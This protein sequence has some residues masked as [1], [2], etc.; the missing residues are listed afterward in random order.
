M[1]KSIFLSVSLVS[2]LSANPLDNIANN[3]SSNF[4]N[5][6]MSLLGGENISTL[7]NIIKN[8]D[9]SVIGQC[10]SLPKLN[11]ENDIC[12]YMPSIQQSFDVCSLA[13]EIPG[14]TKKSHNQT[15]G[16]DLKQY[17]RNKVK[18]SSVGGIVTTYSS[19]GDMDISGGANDEAEKSMLYNETKGSLAKVF[20]KGKETSL[21]RIATNDLNQEKMRLISN[22]GLN[23]DKDITSVT[24]DDVVDSSIPKND[25]EYIDFVKLRFT[26]NASSSIEYSPYNFQKIL[27]QKLNNQPPENFQKITQDFLSQIYR[28]LEIEADEKLNFELSKN[29]KKDYLA[30]PNKTYFKALRDDLKVGKVLE[31]NKQLNEE[32]EVYIKNREELENKKNLLALTAEKTMIM[33]VKFNAEQARAEIE[34]LIK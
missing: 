25:K 31:F 20:E 33:S 27:K 22:I 2:L 6:V 34:A 24:I 11:V 13:P 21:I 28:L 16:L 12:S 17:C 4:G 29:F 26:K 1:K 7:K 3:I 19:F 10:Y 15:L 14:L 30:T 18:Y 5:I 23:L 32:S 9:D 8:V